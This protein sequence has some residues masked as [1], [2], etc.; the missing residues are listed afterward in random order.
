MRGNR[1]LKYW[2]ECPV[3][4]LG[5]KEGAAMSL[6]PKN[7]IFVSDLKEVG[8]LCNDKISHFIVKHF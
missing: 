7:I 5:L 1:S 8:G 3:G 2:A 6:L 4:N